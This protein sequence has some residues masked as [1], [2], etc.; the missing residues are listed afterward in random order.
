MC[1]EAQRKLSSRQV[2][3][4][5]SPQSG[6]M[7]RGFQRHQKSLNNNL[8][9]KGMTAQVQINSMRLEAPMV[10]FRLCACTPGGRRSR[11]KIKGTAGTR[12][13]SPG[14]LPTRKK[15]GDF[16]LALLA[17]PGTFCDSWSQSVL[18][19]TLDVTMCSVHAFIIAISR[20][21][22]HQMRIYLVTC[23]CPCS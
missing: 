1:H 21:S 11:R 15:S 10:R 3:V 14:F 16:L 7:G 13:A 2:K 17:H 19:L 12:H 4:P 23:F 6:H 5:N 22:L 8:E 20:L 9:G 18:Q